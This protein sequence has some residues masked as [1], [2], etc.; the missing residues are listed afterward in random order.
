MGSSINDVTE[1]GILKKNNAKW[2][3]GLIKVE[4]QL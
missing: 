2:R 4:L 3:E 1:E